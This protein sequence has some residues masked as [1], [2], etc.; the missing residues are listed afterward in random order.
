MEQQY[1]YARMSPKFKQQPQHNDDM[2]QHYPKAELML[3]TGI[4]GN[5]P[6]SERPVLQQLIEQVN[7]GDTVL[8]WWLNCLGNNFSDIRHSLLQF[9]DKGVTV[10]T[11]DQQL[12]LDSNSTMLPLLK[13]LLSGFANNERH[14]RLAAAEL[15]RQSLRQDPE[16]WRE[17]FKGRK[18]NKKNHIKIAT[19]LI[20]GKTLQQTAEEVGVSLSTV[21]RVKAKIIEKGDTGD[22]RLRNKH[23]HHHKTNHKPNHD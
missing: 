10:N 5:I 4:R 8:V 13:T 16:Q 3:E 23:H 21:K 17:K 6:A 19:A 11:F 1:I 20:E 2:L 15:S 9:I 7:K 18:S 14:S 12:S 22:M